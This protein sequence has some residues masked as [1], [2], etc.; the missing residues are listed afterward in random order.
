MNQLRITK[1]DPS[2]RDSTGAFM[3]PDWTSH[4]DIGGSFGGRVLTEQEYLRV[5]SAYVASA[6]ALLSADGVTSL[7]VHD[8][9]RGGSIREGQEI[10]LDS[11][12]ALFRSVLR[13]EFWC[14]F[15]S[16][17]GA[18]VHFGYDYYMY[19]GVGSLSPLALS[20]AAGL[21]LFVEPFTSPYL[22]NSI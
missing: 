21:G 12:D 9:E 5:E 3:G 16:A 2:L 14:R 7:R 10:G 17:D 8:L 4:S 20:D 6:I 18:F 13:D 11:V 15:E 22:S 1:Y 19:V